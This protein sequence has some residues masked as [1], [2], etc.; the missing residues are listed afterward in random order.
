MKEKF[1]IQFLI[2]R[3]ELKKIKNVKQ[4]KKAAGLDGWILITIG[5]YEYGFLQE[6]NADDKIDGF[7]LLDEWF[8]SFKVVYA[9]LNK[10]S[11][12][13]L[14]YWDEPDEFFVFERKSNLVHIQYFEK[15]YPVI[16]GR[17]QQT[18]VY[19]IKLIAETI[20]PEE[21]FFNTLKTRI[22]EFW[23]EVAKLNINF[24]NYIIEKRI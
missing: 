13:V 18:R 3:T 17:I 22:N 1:D 5:D 8:S 4:Y 10:D 14:D 12:V 19:D 20:V 21:L 11:K 2:S 6:D 16:E 7:E 23:T 24:Q 9:K 15:A